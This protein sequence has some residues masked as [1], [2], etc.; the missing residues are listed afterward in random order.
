M[1]RW[2]ASP[3]VRPQILKRRELFLSWAVGGESLSSKNFSDKDIQTAQHTPSGSVPQQ[4]FHCTEICDRWTGPACPGPA[5][6]PALTQT[7]KIGTDP[8]A[9]LAS[10]SVSPYGR[11]FPRPDHTCYFTLWSWICDSGNAA[12]C[13][14]ASR[15]DDCEMDSFWY[16]FKLCLYSCADPCQLGNLYIQ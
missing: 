14:W 12:M 13:N 16:R 9:A 11:H 15:H 2:L 7:F 8:T 10:Q 4:L 1:F 6:A 5:P 3:I